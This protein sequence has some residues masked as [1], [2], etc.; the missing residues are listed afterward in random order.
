MPQLLL[1]VTAGFGLYTGYK[2]VAREVQRAQTAAQR[3]KAELRR[4]A[5]GSREGNA[6]DL[7]ELVWDEKSA[8]YRPKK[9]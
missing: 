9:A 6:K 2:W 1:L 7:G 4:S 8:A 3:A 5:E